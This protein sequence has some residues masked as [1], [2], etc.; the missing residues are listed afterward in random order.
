MSFQSK[1]S[2]SRVTSDQTDVHPWSNASDRINEELKKLLD[3]DEKVNGDFVNQLNSHSIQGFDVFGNGYDNDNENEDDVQE[4]ELEDDG[5][6]EDQVDEEYDDEIPYSLSETRASDFNYMT[7]NNDKDYTDPAFTAADSY[8]NK[9]TYSL[10]QNEES[11][12]S[13]E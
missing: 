9:N 7:M 3:L 2:S 13:S 4:Y 8:S 5:G 12:D 1:S 10:Y 11:S 6:L